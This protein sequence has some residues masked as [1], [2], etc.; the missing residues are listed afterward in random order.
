MPSFSYLLTVYMLRWREREKKI[1]FLI[2]FSGINVEP[3]S[4]F[5]FFFVWFSEK[6]PGISNTKFYKFRKCI[7]IEG[8]INHW[9][10]LRWNSNSIKV[11]SSQMNWTEHFQATSKASVLRVALFFFIPF[12]ECLNQELAMSLSKQRGYRFY[13][14]SIP[15]CSAIT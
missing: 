15:L 9:R 14:S 11:K 3:R 1:L 5:S 8:K 10:T 4:F 12:G 6:T 13:S 7:E 2:S